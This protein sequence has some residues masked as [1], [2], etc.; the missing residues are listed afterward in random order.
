MQPKFTKIRWS[1]MFGTYA[2]AT[3][4]LV[5]FVEILLYTNIFATRGAILYIQLCWKFGK[6]SLQDGRELKL[7]WASKIF[8][9]P[10]I[11]QDQ[12]FFQTNF[13][14]SNSVDKFFWE[15]TIFYRK[16]LGQDSNFL[17]KKY[18]GHKFFCTRF[19]F[20]KYFYGQKNFGT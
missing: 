5:T 3:F 7:F 18:F 17:G 15:L 6:I 12:K 19:F 8:L 4:F 14:M 11:F 1:K 9:G 13:L 16:F 10:K 20:P 2:Q